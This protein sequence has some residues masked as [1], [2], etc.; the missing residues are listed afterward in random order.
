MGRAALHHLAN[1]EHLV[2]DFMGLE[3]ALQ[4]LFAC[5]TEAAGH[6]T[7]HLTADADREPIPRRDSNGLQGE[8]VICG[9]QQFEGAVLGEVAL[10]LVGTPQGQR[11]LLTQGSRQHRDV[12]P[13]AGAFG[14]EPIVQLPAAKRRQPLIFSPGF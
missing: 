14:I 13:A 8:A 7:A 11:L 2:D 4:T 10:K 1:G 12:V 5:G 3:R 6:G 9:Q